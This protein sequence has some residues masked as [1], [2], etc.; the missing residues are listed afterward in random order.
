MP[1][2]DCLRNFCIIRAMVTAKIHDT[3]SSLKSTF[4][5][6]STVVV[7]LSGGVD[8]AVTAWILKKAGFEV[9]AVF[10]KCYPNTPGCRSE[11]D[12][13]DA[14]KVASQLEIPLTTMDF[15]EEYRQQV[16]NEFYAEYAAGRTPNPDIWCNSRIKFGSFFNKVMKESGADYFA[17]GHYLRKTNKQISKRANKQNNQT[18][19]IQNTKFKIQDSNAPHKSLLLRGVDE[20]KDQSYFL[21]RIPQYALDKSIFPLGGL[22][23]KEVRALA[24]ELDLPVSDKRDSTG[25]CFVGQVDLKEFLKEEIKPQEGNI[26]TRG[27]EVIGMHRGVWYYTYGQRRGFETSVNEPVYVIGKDLEKNELIVGAYE[28]TFV[29]DFE[30]DDLFWRVEVEQSAVS[31]QQSEIECLVRIRNL[32]ELVPAEVSIKQVNNE[33]RAIAKV[34]TKE[35]IQAPAPG[36]SAVF[37][38]DDVVLGGG[39]IK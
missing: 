20:G 34:T 11:E 38:K 19:E 16:L 29:H 21:Y 6:G 23:K 33:Q 35:K 13:K 14:I 28:E 2:G 4:P 15:I 27:G 32:G 10:L 31:S 36:Q 18:T 39:V 7:G 1:C 37:Y 24:S 25:I 9:S 17:T 22:L 5:T 3:I 26:V 12:L 8:S 30:V